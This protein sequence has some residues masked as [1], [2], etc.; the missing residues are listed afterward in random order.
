MLNLYYPNILSKYF[1]KFNIFQYFY[2]TKNKSFVQPEKLIFLKTDQTSFR[3]QLQQAIK[4]RLRW[5][6]KPFHFSARRQSGLHNRE[7]FFWS[8]FWLFLSIYQYMYLYIF[9]LPQCPKSDG[10]KLTQSWTTFFAHKPI[11]WG[12]TK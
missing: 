8:R 1:K 10:D 4:N 5:N 3:K 2:R 6:K 12:S 11:N 9:C 7:T